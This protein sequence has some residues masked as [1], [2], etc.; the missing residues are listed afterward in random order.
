M[1]TSGLGSNRHRSLAC[2]YT[3]LGSS[4]REAASR[5]FF[6]KRPTLPTYEWDIPD[7][8]PFLS[9]PPAS[10]TEG[11][12]TPTPA[13][14]APP[15]SAP[16]G[17]T[18]NSEE[19]FQRVAAEVA[20]DVTS[21][22]VES[23]TTNIRATGQRPRDLDGRLLGKSRTGLRRDLDTGEKTQVRA[24]FLAALEARHSDDPSGEG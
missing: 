16:S 10:T 24:A 19:V 17:D 3:W 6:C 9:G 1:K 22:D 14:D 7:L 11:S 4:Q 23:L 21:A 8:S 15:V 5:P 2:A 13:S 12:G 20:S 18:E